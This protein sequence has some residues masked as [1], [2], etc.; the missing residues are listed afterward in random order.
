MRARPSSS[1]IVLILELLIPV[2]ARGFQCPVKVGYVEAPPSCHPDAPQCDDGN[3]CSVDRCRMDPEKPELGFRCTSDYPDVDLT[4]ITPSH[5]CLWPLLADALHQAT[6]QSRRISP[7]AR[8]SRE[9]DRV[10][11]LAA[12]S[13]SPGTDHRLRRRYHLV[14][15]RIFRAVNARK[16]PTDVAR[17][18]SELTIP[19]EGVP[20]CRAPD[21]S[22]HGM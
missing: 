17:C 12:A 22:C 7:V 4:T 13:A 18:V 16:L 6:A 15:G 10:R 9:F 1:V 5:L 20:P 14:S 21:E 8:L 19:V 3:P 2:G 11:T